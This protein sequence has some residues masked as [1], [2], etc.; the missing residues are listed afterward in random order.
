M[1]GPKDRPSNHVNL[2]GTIMKT[3]LLLCAALVAADL[4]VQA[5]QA[6]DPAVASALAPTQINTPMGPLSRADVK[7][8][9]R[10]AMQRNEIPRGEANWPNL[11]S[12]PPSSTS[13]AIVKADTRIAL[14]TG[15]IPRGESDLV[16]SAAEPTSTLLRATV[17]AEARFSEER[18]LIPRGEANIGPQF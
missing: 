17:K 2:K 16:H 10:L 13:R 4:L 6:A 1:V 7:A 5:A 8:Q 18:G 15:A 14:A 11:A 9:T 3:N 12:D